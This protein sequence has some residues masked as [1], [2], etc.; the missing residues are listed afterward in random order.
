MVNIYDRLKKRAKKFIADY[1]RG[2]KEFN[3]NLAAY[4][5][6]QNY[7]YYLRLVEHAKKKGGFK[8]V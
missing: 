8:N 4:K 6:Q 5:R 2:G 1:K 7:F 3:E